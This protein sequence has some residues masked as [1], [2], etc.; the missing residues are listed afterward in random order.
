M[1]SR[2]C[3]CSLRREN[4]A[5]RTFQANICIW[6]LLHCL[7]VVL[8][9]VFVRGFDNVAVG[10]VPWGVALQDVSAIT[11]VFYLLRIV[12]VCR[13]SAK[14]RNVNVPSCRVAGLTRSLDRWRAHTGICA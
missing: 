13:G 10:V 1:L 11:G 7:E 6:V 5:P 3:L 8:V 12:S 14:A 4:W 2:Q 9:L